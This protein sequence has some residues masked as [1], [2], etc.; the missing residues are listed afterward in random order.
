MP[1]QKQGVVERFNSVKRFGLIVVKE[2]GQVERF[3]FFED[4]IVRGPAVPLAGMRVTFYV[5]PDEPIQPGRH[6][7]AKQIVFDKS[8]AV[9][10]A[11][12]GLADVTRSEGA[13]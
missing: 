13:K 8:A 5:N 2:D 1:E 3:F 4:Y 12:S 7:L 9:L 6:P 10:A 11:L